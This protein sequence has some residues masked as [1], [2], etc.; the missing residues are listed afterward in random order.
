MQTFD[1]GTTKEAGIMV[2]IRN[3]AKERLEAGELALGIGLRL[4]RTVEIGK[5]MKTAGYD[6]LFIDMEHGSMI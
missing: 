2:S 3:R 5:L 4:A 1:R 6:F